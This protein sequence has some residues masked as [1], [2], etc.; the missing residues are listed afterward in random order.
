M[1]KLK[2]RKKKTSRVQRI[3]IL[4]EEKKGMRAQ[5]STHSP[6]N[7]TSDEGGEQTGYYFYIVWCKEV[8]TDIDRCAHTD[9]TGLQ[10]VK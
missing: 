4:E 6:P 7:Y 10:N 1:Q 9:R 2:Q 3:N 5:I 8:K